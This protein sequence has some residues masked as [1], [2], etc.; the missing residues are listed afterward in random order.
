MAAEMNYEFEYFAFFNEI[1]HRQNSYAPI[2][3]FYERSKPVY[4]WPKLHGGQSANVC[5]VQSLKNRVNNKEEFVFI[6]WVDNVS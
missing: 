5:A 2:A 1:I 3:V 6:N 4:V